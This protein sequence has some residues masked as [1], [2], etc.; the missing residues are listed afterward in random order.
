[1][2]K[3]YYLLAFISASLFVSNVFAVDCT[4]FTTYVAGN[5]YNTGN[6]VKHNN[7]G[8]DCLIDGWCS[9]AAYVPDGAY[10][11]SA[12]TDLG[13]C[14]GG[15]SSS[16]GSSSGGS[17]GGSSSGGSS[18]GSCSGIQVW[19]SSTA[20]DGGE[21]VQHNNV[22]YTADWWTQDNDPSTNN[23][24][25]LP[26]TSNGSCS[27]GSSSGGS[28][29]GGSSS[30]GSSS[31]GSSSGGSSSGGEWCIGIANWVAG[32][33]TQGQIVRRGD[34]KY[35][36][37]SWTTADP[38]DSNGPP[39]SGKFWT[40]QSR[41]TS[42]GPISGALT[43][44]LTE[45]QFNQM[46]PARDPFYTYHGLVNAANSYAAFAGTG[47]TNMKRREI[48]AAL[49]NFEH[50]T[51]GLYYITEIVPN[52]YCDAGYTGCGGGC[53]AD[54]QYFGR[55]PIQLSWNFNYCAAGQAL[56]FGTSLWS[57]PEQVQ[58]NATIAW[59]TAIWYWMTQ[60]GPGTMPAHDCIATNQGF[61]CT[62]RAINGALECD[63]GNTEQVTH[64]VNTFNNY[65]N[66]LGTT[67]V[68]AD[69]C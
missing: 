38:V 15:G 14:S 5:T 13:A 30:G 66:I 11:P 42:E 59:Q 45:L 22:K 41:C 21:V 26:W 29:S 51:G 36:A 28:S 64:R 68:G 62:I 57:N 33:Y 19:N 25:G 12:W 27:G 48:A 31:G 6:D 32:T 69:D 9:Q 44:V 34:W 60:D 55:G 49:A 65:I 1:M 50:E 10:G 46:F 37:A 40:A 20:Y 16:G 3:F 61:G 8:Y 39:G 47:D 63:G 54:K 18:S 24:T 53:A 43:A 7:K 58:N 67:S 17:S 23:G 56:G 52:D 4:G 2:K 35:M